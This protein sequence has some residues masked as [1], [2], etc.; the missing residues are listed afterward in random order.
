[1][2]ISRIA[3]WTFLPVVFF[4]LFSCGSESGDKDGETAYTIS[5]H[6]SG[7]GY[8]AS[9]RGGEVGAGWEA[10]YPGVNAYHANHSVYFRDIMVTPDG[11][12]LSFKLC[13]ESKS[14]IDRLWMNVKVNG[15]AQ[16]STVPDSV[17]KRGG[18]VFVIGPL[19]AGQ[20]RI[21]GLDFNRQGDS[22]ELKLNF[23]RIMERIAYTTDRRD[24]ADMWLKDVMSMN[25]DK[26][27]KYRLSRYGHD[28]WHG[29]PAWSAGGEWL[30]YVRK[31]YVKC[32]GSND[33]REQLYMS[34]PD[35][36]SLRHVSEGIYYATKPRFHP[37]GKLLTFDCEWD[38]GQDFDI[39]IYDTVAET[40]RTFISGQDYYNGNAFHG[41]WS[42][43]GEHF[44][45][46]CWGTDPTVQTRTWM[47]VPVSPQSG[48][49]LSQPVA[50]LQG[51][52]YRKKSDGYYYKLFVGNWEWAPDSRHAAVEVYQY[53]Y[54][55]SWKLSF[56]GLA[57]VDFL[58]IMNST[59]PAVP[60]LVKVA[61]HNE[62]GYAENPSFSPDGSRL[63]FDHFVDGR[64][65]DI[66]YVE[67]ENYK[68]VSG[69]KNFLAN[70]F[71][72]RHPALFPKI[73]ATFYPHNL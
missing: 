65:A 68:P 52:V 54:T 13:S 6:P 63:Y 3:A 42:P 15:E 58:E 19:Q 16:L 35:G 29:Y 64:L 67:L 20:C 71:S 43:D 69:R 44:V 47:H 45:F 23:Y 2:K 36:G 27:D 7:S 70:G 34:H 24:P 25:L 61:D 72:N 60:D 55:G 53:K 38:C 9:L 33:L 18:N 4:A 40:V 22:Y 14:D 57:I 17:N 50:I 73:I 39:C 30:S 59:L 49:T 12:S 32:N 62:G 11:E 21:T 5:V 66:Q 56:R 41:R 10:D 26:T 8:A 37:G 28:G 31:E 46:A 1:M 48:D 51:D